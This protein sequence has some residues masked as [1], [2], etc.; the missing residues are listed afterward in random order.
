MA[1]GLET[2]SFSLLHCNFTIS[3]CLAPGVIVDAGTLSVMLPCL[4]DP[5]E[6]ASSEMGLVNKPSES[7]SELEISEGPKEKGHKGTSI[8]RQLH[9]L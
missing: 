7:F 3:G 5:D 2:T 6:T 9:G 4:F 1:G 8:L